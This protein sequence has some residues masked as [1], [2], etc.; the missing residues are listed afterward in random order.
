MSEPSAAA[1]PV[2]NPAARLLLA[3]AAVA[4]AFAA[5]DT[6]VV[7][8]ALP[9]MMTAGGLGLDE[10]QRAAPIVSGFLL[11]YV[12]VLPL[13]GRIADIRGRRPVLVGSLVLF[14]VG[15]VVTAAAD[16]LTVMVVGRFL[17]G[18]GG[19]GL[20]PATL[21]LVADLW[22]PRR[23]GVP[24][25]IVGAVQELG[26]VLGPLYGAAVLA[27]GDWR[28]IFWLNCAVALVLAAAIA[29]SGRML[30]LS[31]ER[32]SDE[33]GSDERGAGAGSPG[34]RGAGAGSPGRDVLGAALAVLAVMGL[35]LAIGQPDRVRNDVE[36]GTLLLPLVAESRWTT[37]VAL[38][39]YALAAAF[40]ARQL[41]A[42]RPLIAVRTWPA[43]VRAVDLVGAALL[44]L[45][46]GCVIVTFASADPEQSVVSPNAPLLLGAA[47]VATAA[48][49]VRQRTAAA[50]LIPR[51]TLRQRPAWGALVVSLFV[52]AALIAAL[53]DVP[54]FARLTEHR[55]SQLAAA[56]VLVE[57]LVAI[58]V[59]AVVGGY[60]TRRV[61]PAWIAGAGMA[62]ACGCFVAMAGWDGDALAHVSSAVVLALAGLG[63]GLAVAPVNAAL[64][65]ATP[66]ETHGVA[67]AL[68]VVARM[69]GML[70]GISVLTSWGLRAYYDAVDRIP[71]LSEVCP[72]SATACKAYN[73]ELVDAGIV[74]LSTVFAGAAVCAGLAA[75]AAVLLLDVPRRRTKD[76]ATR[77]RPSGS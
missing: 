72:G 64:L 38:A 57:F 53:V 49:V 56:L 63:F 62:L 21:A 70:V 9:D 16:G 18:V 29:A 25:G 67:S 45:A 19:G 26:S 2:A 59:G 37:P 69:V 42:R 34:E 3:L 61:R 66:D 76:A 5:A 60:A 11:G 55:G 22:P 33:R 31:H 14:A 10:L 36:L 47:A 58:P 12:A 74:Q 50:P 6:Y 32:G 71:P 30:A 43:T 24:L 1:A 20:V 35:A 23:R 17:Q 54:F 52:G 41:T 13:V 8:M 15:S 39:T 75:V 7:V 51:R 28:A 27:V 44:G 73:A 4:V 65:D 68:V 77:E 40:V 48:F 46:L